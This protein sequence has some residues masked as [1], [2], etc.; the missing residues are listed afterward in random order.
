VSRNPKPALDRRDNLPDGGPPVIYYSA[1]AYRV[2][3]ATGLVVVCALLAYGIV[4]GQPLNIAA[5]VAVL[6]VVGIVRHAY[7]RKLRG[8][9][10]ALA[11]EG[12]FLVGGELPH[13]LPISATT[14]D[15]VPDHQ[16]SWL[17]VLRSGDDTIRLAPGGWKLPSKRIVDQA[18]ATH[19]LLALGLRERVR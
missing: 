15:V 7:R 4:K 14:F 19:V 1:V 10:V 13:P 6:L 18:A 9:A 5:G 17:V 12:D 3:G 8:G 2:A 11:R 16:G